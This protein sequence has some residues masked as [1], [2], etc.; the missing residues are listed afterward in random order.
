MAWDKNITKDSQY[1]WQRKLAE[2]ER[3]YSLLLLSSIP[4]LSIY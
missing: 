1:D 2:E 3:Y 4:Y